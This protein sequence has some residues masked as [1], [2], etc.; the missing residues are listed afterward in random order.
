MEKRKENSNEKPNT[1]NGNL[2][3]E[4]KTEQKKLGRENNDQR[5]D[6]GKKVKDRMTHM[7]LRT[8]F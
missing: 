2:K 7:E 8:G 1:E 4:N 5:F 3:L 6:D